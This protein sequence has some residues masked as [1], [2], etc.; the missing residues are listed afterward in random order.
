[1]RDSAFH[2]RRR[3]TSLTA[4]RNERASAE[5]A[6]AFGRWHGRV[7]A[8]DDHGAEEIRLL[9]HGRARRPQALVDHGA[10]PGVDLKDLG[11]RRPHQRHG[12]AIPEE[13]LGRR[14]VERLVEDRGPLLAVQV[15]QGVGVDGAAEVCELE[16]RSRGIR[17]LAL[18]EGMEDE[19]LR[20]EVAMSHVSTVTVG[21]A[22]EQLPHQLPQR[23][24]PSLG[25]SQVLPPSRLSDLRPYR[26]P[27]LHARDR[28]ADRSA[29]CVRLR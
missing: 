5:L 3:R 21:D 10:R 14:V 16:K 7:D 28:V 8:V 25:C 17:L 2:A 6:V 9:P 1:M 26:T 11:A 24:L 29:F 23:L 18:A 22:L 4:H 13:N 19:V 15:P 20:L 27:P 12:H